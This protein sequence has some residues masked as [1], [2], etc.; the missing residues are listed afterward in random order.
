M[1]P[2]PIFFFGAAHRPYG[3][4]SNFYLAPMSVDGHRYPSVE[5]YYQSQKFTDPEYARLVRE[6][7]TPYQA[8]Q[9]AGQRMGRGRDVNAV[10]Q[11]HLTRGVRLREDWEGVKEDVMRTG[12]KAKFT[13][14]PDLAAV[15][16]GTGTRHLVEASPYDRYWGHGRDGQGHNRLGC[17]L[18]EL[19][20]ALHSSR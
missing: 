17:L 7:W 15:L 19:R 10:I 6:A 2:E 4:F 1:N 8:K 20:S 14:H 11:R 3:A 13:Q 18:V 9:L 5:H 12:L 16:L